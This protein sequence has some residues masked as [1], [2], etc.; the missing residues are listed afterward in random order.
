VWNNSV[1]GVACPASY[2]QVTDSVGGG[3]LALDM[4]YN[5]A[6]MSNGCIYCNFAELVTAPWGTSS[7]NPNAHSF[8]NG[9][10]EMT[11]RIDA[12]F[13]GSNQAWWSNECCGTGTTW[14]EFDFMEDF[15]SAGANADMAWVYWVSGV[16]PGFGNIS[17]NYPSHDA[18]AYHT[19]GALITGNLANFAVCSYLDG[20]R[21]GC[22]NQSYM[23]G[24]NGAQ[25]RML[26]VQNGVE[27][28]FTPGDSTCVPITFNDSHMYV[29]SLKAVTCAASPT[30]GSCL[31]NTYNGN[32][33]Q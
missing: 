3:N 21:V 19:V 18:T 20:T 2:T 25:R 26:W 33:Y 8:S 31:G 11:Y 16:S 22:S 15:A 13:V 27:C 29:K 28:N 17:P 6:T 1:G 30:G 9:Y 23:A 32:F 12:N 7:S 24:Q 5:R 14:V 10:F 4:H